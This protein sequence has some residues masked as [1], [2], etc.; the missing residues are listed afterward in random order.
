MCGIA[1]IVGGFPDQNTLAAM[2]QAMAHRGPDGQGIWLDPAGDAGL[3]FR[4]LAIIDR[5]P[6]SDQPLHLDPFHLAFNGEIYN[7]LELR[8]ELMR[9]GHVFTT[10]GDGEVLLH[11][12]AEWGEASLER[13]NGM[14][15]FAIWDADKRSLTLA[16]DPFGEKPL[17]WSSRSAQLIFASDIRGLLQADPSLGAPDERALAP[18]IALGVLPP[19]DRSFFGAIAR[20]PGAHILRWRDGRHEV[21]R[22]WWPRPVAVPADYREAAVHLRDLLLD[23]IRLRLRADVPVGTSLSG[24]LDSSAIVALSAQ[25]A[26][27]DHRHA[28]TASFPGFVRDE[29]GYAEAVAQAAGVVAHHLVT[30]Q[31]GELLDDLERLVVDQEEPFGTTSIYAQWRVMAAARDAGVTVLL[32]G[33][34]ADEL[35][36]G[37]DLSGGAALRSISPLAA[38]AGLVRGPGRLARVKSIASESAPV[39]LERRYRRSLASP[40]ASRQAIEDAVAVRPPTVYGRSPLAR[41]LLR[42]TF[43][44]SLPGLLRFADRDSMAHSR[45]LRLPFLDRRVAEF[46][47]SLPPRFLFRDGTT[48]AVL[49]DALRG[50]VPDVVLDRRDKGRFETPEAAWFAGPA[51][52]ARAREVLLD[53]SAGGSD[54]Y[55]TAAVEADARAGRWR[56]PSAL[57]R[58]MNVEMWRAGLATPRRKRA[59]L[60]SP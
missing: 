49:R 28:F 60:A 33:Q 46:A 31:A 51:F 50:I 53:R 41:N 19:V 54:L 13:L 39:W 1:G 34:G 52:V 6:R 4:R 23:S 24:G 36:G 26:G 17:F 8:A 5:Q 48:K 57:W 44:T 25:L 56:D 40:Y 9:A 55:D 32:D 45:E 2:A 22:W 18:F 58:A 47:L 27:D 12:W 42:E 20:L 15:A 38:G 21:A 16:T 3:A 43:H 11:A 7:Y 37:Y 59:R 35:F 14:F 30:P 10:Q 29:T